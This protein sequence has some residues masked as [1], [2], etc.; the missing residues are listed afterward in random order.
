MEGCSVRAD[1]KIMRV[2]R[3]G[4]GQGVASAINRA[5]WGWVVGLS[6]FVALTSE[7][8]VR[9]ICLLFLVLL[10]MLF[11]VAVLVT[12]FALVVL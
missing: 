12:L 5:C 10:L 2:L 6:S 7:G 1:H 4:G 8:M 11:R 9:R 3:T